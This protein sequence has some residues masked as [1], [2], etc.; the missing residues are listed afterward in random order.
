MSHYEIEFN[1]VS[2]KG[3]KSL[4][5]G[6]DHFN[7]VYDLWGFIGYIINTMNYQITFT[8]LQFYNPCFDFIHYINLIKESNNIIGLAL[9]SN[10]WSY[11]LILKEVK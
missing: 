9:D 11:E 2:E 8:R 10:G 5:Y 4:M 6:L 7:N 1:L 3:E